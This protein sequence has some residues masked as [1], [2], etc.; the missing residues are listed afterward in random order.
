MPFDIAIDGVNRANLRGFRNPSARYTDKLPELTAKEMQ[1]RSALVVYLFKNARRVRT[2][3]R[4]RTV[5][6][7]RN[8]RAPWRIVL[9]LGRSTEVG[10]GGVAAR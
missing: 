2:R 4:Q 3:W 8:I 1:D 6:I 10:A 5:A 9:P 7:G